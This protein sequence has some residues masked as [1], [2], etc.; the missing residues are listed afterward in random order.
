MTKIHVL[1]FAL[2]QIIQLDEIMNQYPQL[3]NNVYFFYQ[4]KINLN[5]KT[6]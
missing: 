1:L 2:F 6:I 3:S 4:E 5:R